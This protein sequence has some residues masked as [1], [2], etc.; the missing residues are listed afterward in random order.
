MRNY[1]EEIGCPPFGSSG[2][3]AGDYFKEI[4]SED[5]IKDLRSNNFYHM[6]NKK[7]AIEIYNKLVHKHLSRDRFKEEF[8]ELIK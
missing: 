6:S 1:Y 5:I 8:N 3:A 4:D 7:E 2:S